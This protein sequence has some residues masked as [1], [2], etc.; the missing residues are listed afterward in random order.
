M[1]GL[2]REPVQGWEL[3]MAD[4]LERLYKKAQKK[5]QKCQ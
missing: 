2:G 3:L 4:F 5:R 1:G